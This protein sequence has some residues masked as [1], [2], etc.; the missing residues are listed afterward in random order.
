MNLKQF[1]TGRA[2][3]LLILLVIL[4][5]VA[6]FYSFNNYIYQEKQ[7]VNTTFEPYRA[8]FTGVQTCLPHKNTSGPRTLE[9][10]I[11]I[12]TDTN[13]YYALDFTLMS[14][15]PPEIQN[16]EKFTASGVVMPI[17]RLSADHWQK[18]NAKGI[19]SVT[20]SVRVKKNNPVILN[21][22]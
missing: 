12:Q 2:I 11:G 19:F 3:R 4:G 18:Y 6:G 9:C 7:G 14:Q 20:D 16:G 15:I 22:D 8:T 5:I 13:E 10:A 1:F 17:E 21:K